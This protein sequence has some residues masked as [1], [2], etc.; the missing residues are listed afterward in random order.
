MSVSATLAAVA[1]IGLP[2]PSMTAPEIVAH[3]GYP[4]EVHHVTTEDGYELEL[5]R[6]PHGAAGPGEAERPV[7]FLNHCLLCSSADYLMNVP[8]K[9]LAYM[10][11]DA[12]YDVWMGNFRGNTYSRKHVSLDPSQKKFWEFSWDEMALYD[13]PAMIDYALSTAAQ[14]QL[15]LVGFSMGTTTT[16]AMLSE[17]PEYNNK[18]KAAALMAPVAYCENFRGFAKVLAPYADRLDFLATLLGRYEILPGGNKTDA[19]AMKFCAEDSELLFLCRDVVF[20]IAGFDPELLNEEWLQLMLTHTP[21][22]T[23]VHTITHY[24]QLNQE[25]GFLKYDYGR[26]GNKQHYGQDTPP[27]F[28]LSSVAVPT[29]LFWGP[30]DFLAA[31]EDVATLAGELPN[32]QLN[33]RVPWDKFNH[34]DFVWST[35]AYNI[36][37]PDLMDFLAKY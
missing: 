5:H 37:Y 29:A 20:S 13:L 16:M 23:S 12:G 17:L 35:E 1:G 33:M 9:A 28:N 6:I 8:E 7:V 30:N 22:G 25:G 34:L 14:P 10:L 21:A 4:A 18:I 19:L 11:A 2:D 24:A 27:A 32:L 36:V 3:Y 15:S 31:P 26:R